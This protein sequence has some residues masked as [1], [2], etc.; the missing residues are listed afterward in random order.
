MKKFIYLKEVI[1]NKSTTRRTNYYKKKSSKI[2]SNRSTMFS[3][4]KSL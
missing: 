1:K 4:K 3:F 2:Q